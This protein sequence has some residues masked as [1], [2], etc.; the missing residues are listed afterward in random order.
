MHRQVL[1][2]IVA[3]AAAVGI[4]ACGENTTQLGNNQAVV[5]DTDG[6]VDQRQINEACGPMKPVKVQ[7]AAS[8]SGD[9]RR[10]AVV[11]CGPR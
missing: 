11:T 6:N 1:V 7:Y 9:K 2:I 3:A 10:I 8:D 4:A 5:Y